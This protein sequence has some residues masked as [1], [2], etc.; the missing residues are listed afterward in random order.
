MDP[1]NNETSSGTVSPAFKV[2]LVL[3]AA[4]S[5]GYTVHATRQAKAM[6]VAAAKAEQLDTVQANAV[7]ARHQQAPATGTPDL[8][9]PDSLPS[10]LR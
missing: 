8:Y 7:R 5:V 1:H 2:A 10:T 9:H 6:E 4:I 3:L